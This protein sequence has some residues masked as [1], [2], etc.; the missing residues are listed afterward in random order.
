MDRSVGKVVRALRLRLA[1]RQL[2]L[3]QRAG[4]S[5]RLISKLE[6]DGPAGITVHTLRRICEPLDIDLHVSGRWR[7]GELDRL[8]DAG[9]AAVQDTF[10]RQL[11]AAGWIVRVEVTFSRYGE[12]GSIDLLALHAATGTLLVVEIKT[13]IADVQGL[14]RPIDAKVRL[15]MDIGRDLGWEPKAVVAALVVSEDS[16]SR[17]RVAAHAALFSRFELRGWA[18]RRWLRAP[19]GGTS[20]VLLV[21]DP[22][23]AAGDAPSQPGRQRIRRAR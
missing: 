11:E 14:L 23:H 2:D 5:R 3:A 4:V 10:K 19:D 18:A 15:A 13:V 7:G 20:G 6:R 9:H 17:R 16:T 12:R 21:V 8:L 22:S 1:W